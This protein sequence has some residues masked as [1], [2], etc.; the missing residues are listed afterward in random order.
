MEELVKWGAYVI[1]GIIGWIMKTL[2][3]RH[4]DLEDKFND[5][6]VKLPE[7][8]VTK[9]ELHSVKEDL[10]EIIQP[11]FRKLDRIEEYLMKKD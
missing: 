9:E 4:R 1:Y 2:Y 10:K 3:E 5:L 11:I 8:Y 7:D 6:K